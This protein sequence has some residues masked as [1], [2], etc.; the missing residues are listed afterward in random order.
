MIEVVG[1]W[2]ITAG[3]QFR[4]K[5]F[6]VSFVV[7]KM[8]LGQVF[9]F[10]LLILFLQ[11]HQYPSSSTFCSVPQSQTAEAWEPS[12]FNALSEIWSVE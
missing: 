10:L 6:H 2:P 9:G 7:N 12:E 5:P 1:C 3:T 4:S 8:A 11:F